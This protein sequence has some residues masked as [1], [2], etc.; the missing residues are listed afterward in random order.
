[1]SAYKLPKICSQPSVEAEDGH[2]ARAMMRCD[3]CLIFRHGKCAGIEDRIG[4]GE[5]P[6]MED[7]PVK[8][9]LKDLIATPVEKKV[10]LRAWSVYEKYA[11]LIR[12]A[13][14]AGHSFKEI[15]AGLAK[16]TG[17]KITPVTISK[18]L[19]GG[20]NAKRQGDTEGQSKDKPGAS[21]T[22]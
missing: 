8:V 4:L 13:N 18:H 5:W 14:K 7:D 12:K 11:P 22:P 10:T 17:K 2:I 3:E 15:A 9:W 21:T 6:A 16:I 1:M 19:G 20:K